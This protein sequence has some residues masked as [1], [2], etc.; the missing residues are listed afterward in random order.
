MDKHSSLLQIFINFGH[1]KFYNMGPRAAA[2]FAQLKKL[3]D[4]DSETLAQKLRAISGAQG[5]MLENF[6][7]LQFMNVHS[8]LE[9]LYRP[10]L[11]SLV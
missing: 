8:K 7:R 3:T 10:G 2:A 4:G 11:S 9:C 1:K 6:L 5:P